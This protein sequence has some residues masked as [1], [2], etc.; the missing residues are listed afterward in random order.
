MKR[1][2]ILLMLALI[3]MVGCDLPN[4]K[5]AANSATAVP[6]EEQGAT[7]EEPAASTNEDS[8]KVMLTFTKIDANLSVSVN[9]SEVIMSD[10][11][12]NNQP[13]V[14]F[15]L[16]PHMK[17]NTQNKVVLH[18][19]NESG[20]GTMVGRLMAGETFITAWDFRNDPSINNADSFKY[21]RTIAM[22]L[23][24]HWSYEENL[25]EWG[26]LDVRY[27]LCGEG[28]EQSPIDIKAETEQKD[29]AITFEYKESLLRM[30]NNGHTVEVNYKNG[31]FISVDDVQYD[32]DQFHHHAPSEHRVNG[33]EF[34]AEF[35]IVHRSADGKLAV[36]GLL[37]REGKE[38]ATFKQIIDNM[39]QKYSASYVNE[40]V[41]LGAIL[42]QK[43]TVYKYDG[44][45]T[46][47][48]CSENVQGLVRTEPIE[49]SAEQITTLKELF[50]DTH[51]NRPP[52]PL[53]ERSLI[54]D[55]SP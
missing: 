35:H 8:E 5:P 42:P 53:N 46:T 19:T 9:D 4:A 15:D 50:D 28:K 31:S 2:L 25:N 44:S 11:R 7:S 30:V 52:Q 13:M 14:E 32:V 22:P 33:E 45:L 39:P 23:S 26:A 49:L 6:A 3:V 43:H 38:N 40:K 21:T 17:E 48:P 55:T 10:L 24:A 16:T 41:N 51:T 54:L 34:A 47:P 18:A 1:K 37:V 20:S 27:E 29:V 36:I 12:Q